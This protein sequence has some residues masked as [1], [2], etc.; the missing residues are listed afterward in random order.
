MLKIYNSLSRKKE[1]FKPLIKGKVSLYVCGIT[2]YDYCHIGHARTVVA[3][4]MI[5]R[6]LQA[7][8]YEV[9][10]VRNIT[11]I[12]DKIIKRANDSGEEINHLTERFIT[13]MHED[14][15]AL[16]VR[17]PSLEPK[18]T[19]HMP[20]MIN[21]IE[22]L[23]EHDHAYRATN[24]DVYYRVRSFKDYGQLSHRSLDDMRAGE[25]VEVSDV[26]E[27]PMDFVLW[28]HAKPHEPHWESPWG[29]G[30]PGWHIECSA[31]AT[32]CLGDTFDIHGGGFDLTFPH[33]E[34]EIAQAE[35][36]TGK[37]FV[38]TWM[39][40]GFVN[41]DDE[42]MSKSLNNFFTIREVLAEYDA[43]VVRLFLL[44]SH[45]RSAV[46][47]SLA[48]LNK[49][50]ASLQRLY[51]ALRGRRLDG[52]VTLDDEIES[53]FYDAMNDDF[54]TPE[55]LA[56]MF[57]LVRDINRIKDEQPDKA[58]QLAIK[59]VKLGHIL[60]FL[61]R[62]PEVFLQ[63]AHDDVDFEESQIDELIVERNRARMMKDFARADEIRK[64]L[65]AKG[66]V[67]EDGANGTT[68]RREH[69]DNQP[70]PPEHE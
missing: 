9:N 13:A 16:G 41:I 63:G 68:W 32:K 11:D 70:L 12:D 24:D 5:N 19:E 55:A 23:R 38:N 56:V 37:K 50:R 47:Y 25:R 42:K 29:L 4:D 45:Y 10:Y 51:T 33:H 66:I 8:G 27:D 36:A 64:L 46:N 28:K 62:D 59:L 43:E 3:F 52:D 44:S 34:N 40:V 6:Y 31:M 21:M 20:D 18:A 7:I 15:D 61:E 65:L 26:K 54:N 49:A 39:H 67:L 22:K 69:V 1:T 14:F 2:V 35:G 57:E 48:N 60:G 53:R 58:D 30:R 17:R